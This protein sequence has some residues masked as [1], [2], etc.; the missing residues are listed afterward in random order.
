MKRKLVFL[1][2][3][4]FGLVL[5]PDAAAHGIN[6]QGIAT[7]GADVF[8]A[9]VSADPVPGEDVTLYQCR[10]HIVDAF[11]ASVVDT[12]FRCRSNFFHPGADDATF[13]ATD[14][15]ADGAESGTDFRI[16]GAQQGPAA[17]L[18]GHYLD[19]ALV[20]SFNLVPA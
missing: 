18:T 2:F 1:V 8:R 10:V 17:H 6:S 19:F 7:T 16:D 13:V 15:W 3:A 4:L 5:A 9:W 20:L 14:L 11:G 12:A